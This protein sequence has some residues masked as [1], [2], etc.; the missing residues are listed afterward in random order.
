MRNMTEAEAEKELAG[1]FFRGLVSDI[2]SGSVPL[3]ITARKIYWEYRKLTAPEL[4]GRQ[5][6]TCLEDY[7]K[8]WLSI[9]KGEA[10]EIEDK[11]NWPPKNKVDETTGLNSCN[12]RLQ[13]EQ[14][15]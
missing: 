10:R 1:S 8:L 12:V 2:Q 6:K 7:K 3:K 4:Q 13:S 11:A 14:L 5:E 15:R 9:T